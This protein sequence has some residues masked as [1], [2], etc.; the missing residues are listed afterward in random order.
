MPQVPLDQGAGILGL[1]FVK[2][3]RGIEAAS[4]ERVV[5]GE[6]MERVRRFARSIDAKWYQAWGKNFSRA[7]TKAERKAAW[8]RNK[9][10]L[11]KQ[12]KEGKEII[13]I[14]IEDGKSTFY[15]LERAFIHKMKYPYYKQLH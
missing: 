11:L 2:A 12:M 3:V 13:D 6:G 1:G 9:Q 15:R 7:M 14:G 4:K 5:I 10:W 8:Q